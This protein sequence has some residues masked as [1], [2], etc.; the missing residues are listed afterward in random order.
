MC[1][2]AHNRMCKF[3]GLTKWRDGASKRHGLQKIPQI[4]MVLDTKALKVLCEE[5]CVKCPWPN[6]LATKHLESTFTSVKPNILKSFV[7]KSA[8][9]Y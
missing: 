8:C 2:C 3:K 5:V 7:T 4:L 9:S 1:V 6:F